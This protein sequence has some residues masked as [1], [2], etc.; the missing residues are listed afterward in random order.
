MELIFQYPIWFIVFCFALGAIYAGILYFKTNHFSDDAPHFIWVKRALAAL[1]FLSVSI[2]AF[3]LLSPFIKSKF[4]DKVNP[5]IVFAHDNSESILLNLDTEDSTKYI[6]NTNEVLSQLAE[7]YQI[8]YFAFANDIQEIDTL[9]FKGKSSNLSYALNQINGLYFNQNVGAVIF[10]TDGIY[11]EGNNPVYNDFSF[12]IYAVALGD[13]NQQTD[14]KIV[15]VRNNKIAYLD[16][17]VQVEVD[18]QANHLKGKNYRLSLTQKGNTLANKTIPITK[19]FD[20]QNTSFSID[21]N[22][23]GIQKYRLA[24]QEVD[25]EITTVNNYFDFYIEVIDNRQ[26]IL[27][28]ANAPHPDIAAIKSVIATNKNFEI[29]VQYVNKYNANLG[30][31]SLVIAHQIPSKNSSTSNILSDIKKSK[32]PTW[33]I[34]GASTNYT[35]FNQAQSIVQIS[36]NGNNKNDASPYFNT[37]FSSFNL[38]EHTVQNLKKFPPVVVPFGNYNLGAN[39]NILLKQKIGAVDADFP[40]IAFQDNLGSRSAIFLGD[41]LWRW[42]LHDYLENNTNEAFN[43][44]VEKTINY[45]ALKGDKRKFRVNTNKN[46]FIEGENIAFEA[47]LYNASYEL[48]NEPEVSM[49]VKNDEG[50]EFPFTFSKTE[51]AY[52]YTTNSLPIG[53]YTY[54]A[55]TT[56]DGNKLSASGAFTINDTQ[57]EALHT[58]ANHNLLKQLAQKTKGQFIEAK[59]VAS[60]S[61]ILLNKEDIKPVLYESFKTR[62]IINL[63]GLF[64]VI[65]TLLSVEWFARKWFGA[66]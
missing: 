8:D 41:G 30:D 33:F 37:T 19:D 36:T 59:D 57:L 1:R 14:I 66:Y 28:I 62:P 50:D 53:N 63:F 20:E 52:Q 26:K 46:A 40:V 13:T 22:S 24:L 42:K 29:E 5:I 44:I 16:D 48:V 11:N 38:S 55:N 43:E 6:N 54:T 15:N 56:F 4:V 12:P 65:M 23:V 7:K 60:L 9:D 10:A 27:L 31:Y 32:I 18:L 3:L 17:K 21:A 34:T 47:E 39:T 2:L 35:N 51:K 64:F 49:L 45:L 61:E 25:K 58:Q